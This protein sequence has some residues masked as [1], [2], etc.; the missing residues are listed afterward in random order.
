MF[1]CRN[2]YRMI[3]A[4]ARTGLCIGALLYSSLI[5]SALAITL[6]ALPPEGPPAGF[7]AEPGG[8]LYTA[9]AIPGYID[10]QLL[11]PPLPSA[12]APLTPPL[13]GRHGDH[14]IAPTEA[15]T[16]PQQTGPAGWAAGGALHRE[17]DLLLAGHE[18]DAGDTTS[19]TV[20]DAL[21][22]FIN[23]AAG[24]P[25]QGPDRGPSGLP[26]QGD[27]LGLVR[28]LLE[29]S[30]SEAQAAQLLAITEPWQDASGTRHFSIFGLGD[31]VIESTP[32]NHHATPGGTGNSAYPYP[33]TGLR[34]TA[35]ETARESQG[36]STAAPLTLKEHLYQFIEDTIGWPMLYLLITAAALLL[37][38]QSIF[39][40]IH[41]FSLQR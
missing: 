27:S 4:M 10:P 1:I 14:P 33:A 12:D 34:P 30:L 3:R 20:E 23:D 5:G 17:R 8:H 22:L 39:R 13:L 11:Q 35:V 6:E 19:I 41:H 28:Q 2:R 26:Y 18:T 16:D 38:A 29:L 36:A 9:P 40:V 7:A 21:R 31:F 37:L 15:G 24:G 32:A 25:S